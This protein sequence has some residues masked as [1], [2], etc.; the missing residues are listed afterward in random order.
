L[1]AG[2]LSETKVIELLNAYFV[3]VYVS[4][5]DYEKDGSAP[6]DERQAYQSIYHEALKEKRS[7]GS[8][9]VYLLTPEGKGLASMIVS[10]AAE[11]GKLQALLEKT[12]QELKTAA[13]KPAIRPTR[14]AAPPRAAAGELVFHLVSRY[15]HRGSW[16]EFPAENYIVLGKSDLAQLLPGARLT[17]GLTWEV[18]STPAGKLLTYFFP[19]TEMCD[20]AKMTLEDGPYKHRIEKMT[21]NA[22]VVSIKD[23]VAVV[24]L[25]GSLQLRHKFY[26][27]HDDN[28]RVAATLVGYMEVGTDK[29]AVRALRLVTSQATYANHAFAAVVRS[30]GGE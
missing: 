30:L 4:N 25:D 5:E 16:A 11:K 3:P 22:R 26:P 20:C 17:R 6:G 18:A 29:S 15:D 8:V 19:Q 24:R 1:R 13:G 7:A 2:P 27:N 28:N 14:Q 21:L 23:G 9:C 10:T 12:V